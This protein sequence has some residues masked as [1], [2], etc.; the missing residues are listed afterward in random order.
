MKILDFIVCDD[1]RQEI[2][3]KHSLM[4]VYND[5][6]VLQAKS[7]SEF[8]FPMAL[9]C[10][11]YLRIDIENTQEELAHV[12]FS[13]KGDSI[14]LFEGSFS[15]QKSFEHGRPLILVA[16]NIFLNFKGFG[17]VD[18]A[19]SVRNKAGKV[20]STMKP[21]FNFSVQFKQVV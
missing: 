18:I 11:F 17:P 21:A 10:A 1:V 9:K 15:L 19:F 14:E 13:F 2:G 12:D 5:Q 6:I 4:G 3:N 16:P 7:I 20:V 8:K